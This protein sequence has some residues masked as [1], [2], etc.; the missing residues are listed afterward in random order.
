MID[1]QFVVGVVSITFLTAVAIVMSYFAFAGPSRG[2]ATTAPDDD[3][4]TAE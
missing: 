1:I 3:A 2:H 4:S